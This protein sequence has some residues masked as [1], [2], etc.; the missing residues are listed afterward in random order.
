M[1]FEA[2]R[3]HIDQVVADD[4]QWLGV[5]D[6]DGWPLMDLPLASSVK[7]SEVKLGP[8]SLEV[9]VPLRGGIG[10]RVARDL[11]ADDVLAEDGAGRLVPSNGPTRLVCVARGGERRAYLISH[12]HVEGGDPPKTVTIYGA[13]FLEGLAWWP[14]PSIP[15]DWQQAKFATWD[16]DASGEKYA[17]PRQLAQLK[18]ADQ[19]D[20][21]TKKGP[22]RT[23]IRDLIQDSFD[24]VNPMKGWQDDDHAVVDYSGGVDTSRQVLIRTDDSYVWDTVSAPAKNAGVGIQ[25][26]LWWPGDGEVTVRTQDRQSTQKMSWSYPIQIVRVE[27]T[28]E[29]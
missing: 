5:L 17:K 1:D 13:D 18:F 14:C 12:V 8:G 21:Y 2:W 22:A 28:R 25:V 26:D 3:K 23:V 24:A 10:G 6:E 7:A 15:L 20:G 9:T 29:V 27:T 11:V 16:T 4:G 19:A